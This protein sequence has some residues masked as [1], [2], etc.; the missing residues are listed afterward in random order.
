MF[1]HLASMGASRLRMVRGTEKG[2]ETMKLLKELR[3]EEC[4][5]EDASKFV[6]NHVCLDGDQ[7]IATDGRILAVVPCERSEGDVDGL[8]PVAALRAARKLA[9]GKFTHL[10]MRCEEKQC[11]LVDGS[12]V[13]RPQDMKFPQWKK[14][15]PSDN[16]PVHC[17]IAFN[18]DLLMAVSKAFGG[19][20]VVLQIAGD[21]DS[22]V[23]KPTA[24][25][26]ERVSSS[27]AKGIMMPMRMS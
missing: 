27:D 12:T 17:K 2:L 25:P 21:I 20:A 14:V 16:R 15:V 24:K 3:I 1:R 18:P 10:L 22:I 23:I 8:I 6:I 11:V 26:G 4:V 9:N 13:P 19:T 7:L 5:S